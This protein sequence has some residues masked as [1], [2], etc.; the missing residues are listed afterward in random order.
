MSLATRREFIQALGAG[1]TAVAVPSLLSSCASDDVPRPNILFIMSDDHAAQ[2]ISAYGSRINQTPNIDRLAAEGVRFDHCFATNAICA[3]SRASIL[4]GTYS[5]VHGVI[6]NDGVFDGAQTTFPKLLREAGYE[7]ALFGKWHLKSAPTGFDHYDILPGQGHYYN[8]DFIRNGERRREQGYVTDLTTD[9]ALDWLDHRQTDKPF[10]VMLHHKAPHRNW[11]P[12]PRHYGLYEDVDIPVPETFDDDYATRSDAARD[13]AMSI[14]KDLMPGYDLKADAADARDGQWWASNYNRMTPSQKKVWDAAYGPRNRE[15][16]RANLSG[17]ALKQW[18]YQRYIKDYLRC[19]AAVDEN[20]GRVLDHL[21]A[22][23]QAENTV[24]VYTSD[25]GFFL[26]EH[27]WFD[28]RFMYEESLRM[29]CI[30]RYPQ[31]ISPGRVENGLA[32]NVDFAPT[33][34]D[35]AGVHRP[36]RVQGRS[37]RPLLKGKTPYDWR[38][39]VYY[40]Y[41]EYPGAHSVKRHYGLRTAR[42]KLIHFYHDI[43]A[44]ELYDLK[45]DPQELNNLAGVPAFA[46]LFKKLKR[47]LKRLRRVHGDDGMKRFLPGK[48]QRVDHLAVGAS[49][50][51]AHDASP[52]YPGQGPGS[53]VNGVIAPERLGS[54]PDCS[55]WQGFEGVDL[56]AVIDLGAVQAIEEVGAAFLAHAG[57]WIFMPRRV[58]IQLSVDGKRWSAAREWI[59]EDVAQSG[60]PAR[61]TV[62][63]AMGGQ[64]AR[65]ILVKAVAQGRCPTGHPGAGQ[66]CW[67]FVD[68]I[69]VN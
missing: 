27:G 66:P 24:V 10:C 30:V 53:L 52:R 14:E 25:Q 42:Y 7:T 50:Q 33:F 44:Y 3:P 6:D 5:H 23:G 35:Y 17:Q 60:P 13:Q 41:F 65:F 2:A 59:D 21:D 19:I 11:M 54:Q 4:T 46:G 39:A 9:L 12:A 68:E 67:L 45:N 62:A 40:H 47:E 58:T 49:I 34:L 26:G 36:E 16:R 22:T 38:Q 55:L 64:S 28:K 18:K 48:A 37:L 57:S 32:A 51:L 8:P 56:E 69:V 1:A 63:M 20:V 29:P 15:A 31:E 43:D 61:R